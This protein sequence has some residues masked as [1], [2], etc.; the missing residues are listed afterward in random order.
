MEIRTRWP[1]P[2]GFGMTLKQARERAGLTLVTLGLAVG[3][4][5]SQLSN[6]ERGHYRPSEPL[7]ERIA[8]V[9]PFTE[10]ERAV[11]LALAVPHKEMPNGWRPRA[12]A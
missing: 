5:T 3:V 4:S 10:W 6:L 1:A 12:A 8:D 2:P 11:W 9:V 7:A